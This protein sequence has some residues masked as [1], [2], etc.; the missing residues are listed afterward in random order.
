MADDDLRCDGCGKRH[1][2]PAARRGVVVASGVSPPASSRRCAIVVASITLLLATSSSGSIVPSSS[3]GEASLVPLVGDR[4]GGEWGVRSTT[5][6]RLQEAADTAVL[7]VDDAIDAINSTTTVAEEADHEEEDHEEAYATNSTATVAEEEDH[8]EGDHEEEAPD[9]E[10]HEGEDHD[11]E[12]YDGEEEEHDHAHE[13]EE[14]HTED[15]FVA[16]TKPYGVVIGATLLVNLATLTGLVLVMGSSISG[17]CLKARG[18]EQSSSWATREGANQG[19]KLFDVMIYSFAVGALL[20]TAVFLVL[21]EALVLIKGGHESHAGEE[22]AH[23]RRLLRSLQEDHDDH[24]GEAEGEKSESVAA[25]Q[26]GCAFLGGFLLPLLF[27]IFFHVDDVDVSTVD[28]E[29]DDAGA[30]TADTGVAVLP[31]ETS[32]TGTTA[33]DEERAVISDSKH[34]EEVAIVKPAYNK[35]LIASIILGD[36]LH[37]FADGMFIAAS[38]VGCD[39]ALTLTI[40]G[41]TL[42]HEC[43]QEIGDFVLLTRHGGLSVVRALMLNF[44]SGMSVVLGGIVFLTAKPSD[45]SAGIILAMAAGVYVNIAAV[46][47][48]PRIENIVKTRPDRFWT[49]FGVIL[50]AVPIGLVLLNHTHC[51]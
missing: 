18:V 20:A 5:T 50:G 38:F 35:K 12:E 6:R 14:A 11:E 39:L 15:E 28:K 47:T 40:V 48:L 19:G 3:S 51:D 43:A 1:S 31:K 30:E 46:E 17:V 26:F 42:V 49:L 22:D 2:R 9:E 29:G 34:E 10:D 21:P 7:V 23:R 32:R 33:S 44:V 45:E 37:N 24:G 25:A 41:V 27:A 16:T 36:S 4:H 13:G 8:V